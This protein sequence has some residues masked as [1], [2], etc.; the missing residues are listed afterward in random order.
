MSDPSA[1]SST[2]SR[3]TYEQQ[4]IERLA[5]LC[6]ANG[7]E[8]ELPR[9][10][11]LFR[12]L[13]APWSSR[14]IGYAADIWHSDVADDHTP[15]EFSVVFGGGAP[16]L[17][18]LFEAQG[19]PPSL[20]SNWAAG[21]ALSRRIAEQFQVSL[22]RHDRVAELF[23][24]GPHARLALWHAL[25]LQRGAP[26]QFKVYFDAQ[27]QGR[28][29]ASALVEE[30]LCR[31]GFGRAWPAIQHMG[32]RGLGVDELKYLSLDL[33][34]SDVGRVKVYWRHHGATA[35][36]IGGLM[37]PYGVDG[38]D[39]ADFCRRLGGTDGPYDARPIFSCTT[40]IDRRSALPQA[41]TVYLPIAAY[42]ASDA[43]AVA[44]VGG[45][46]EE[47]GLDTPRYRASIEQ[48]APRSLATTSGL[49]SYVSLQQRG[50]RRQVTVYFSPE[51]HRVDAA[52]A[53]RAVRPSPPTFEPAE[54][55]V[56]RYEREILL[57]D[58]PFLRRLAREPVNL[59]HLWLVMVNFWE[60]IVHDFPA[61]LAHVLARVDDDRVRCIVTKQLNDELGEG[62]YSQAHKPMY[63]ALLDALEPH[64]LPGDLDTLL[65]AGRE[66][67]RR[68]HTHLFSEDP[69]EAI[70]ALMMIEIYGKQTDLCMGAEFRR[71]QL[72]G[73]DATKWL[74]LHETLE[75]DHAEDSL[76]LARLLPRPGHGGESD[77]G[78]AAAWRGAEGVVA[79]GW[80]YFTALYEV[81]YA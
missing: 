27:A 44:R 45:Y 36:E 32:S 14:A 19:D 25:A 34:G 81:C 46:L 30:A 40:L 78:L 37:N 59:G 7:F 5:S 48:Y 53:P 39:V 3:Q 60:A 12:S 63:R 35:R 24:P 17:R 2:S 21:L 65:T 8:D 68:I 54:A 61:R 51:A 74:R 73:G 62:N 52:H 1:L 15:Y 76:R 72:V 18:I 29:R 79:A 70:G 42:T 11:E 31:L 41:T 47:H 22:A 20:Q 56:D 28:W 33:T 50:E 71:Q 49:Q 75:V 58:H 80:A 9:V 66:F 4:A 67:G 6:R 57:A 10:A 43:V 77:R 26:P 38:T 64:R 16:E 13:T 55:I 69:E 23:E